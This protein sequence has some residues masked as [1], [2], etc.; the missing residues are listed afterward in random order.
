MAVTVAVTD[1]TLDAFGSSTQNSV[2]IRSDIPNAPDLPS[3][4]ILS[5]KPAFACRSESKD[6]KPNCHDARRAMRAMRSQALPKVFC[7]EAAA[8][9]P[10]SSPPPRSSNVKHSLSQQNVSEKVLSPSLLGMFPVAFAPIA[11][12]PVS[13]SSATSNDDCHAQVFDDDAH[14]GASDE[15]EDHDE[16][17]SDGFSCL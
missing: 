8:E 10:L 2:I 14:S 5:Q 12:L 17:D 13:V 6:S 15:D 7:K 4:T 1:A 3:R 16:F 11:V 9:F